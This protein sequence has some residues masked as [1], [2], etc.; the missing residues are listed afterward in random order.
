M[1]LTNDLS[2][3]GGD[4]KVVAVNQGGEDTCTA[5]LNVRGRAPTFIEKPLKCTI[6]EGETLVFRCRVDGDPTPTVSWSK[7]KWKQIKNNAKTRVYLDEQSGQH[8]CEIDDIV[9]KDAGTYTV[10][11]ENEFGSDT[12]PATLMVTDKPEEAED[13]KASLKET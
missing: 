12:C 3:M 11:I 6:L 1:T 2:D 4:I 5:N 13:W 8:V 7:G 9:K 10:N